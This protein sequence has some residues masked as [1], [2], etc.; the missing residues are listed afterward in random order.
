MER[1]TLGFSMDLFGITLF[2]IGK[3]EKERVVQRF[4]L[5]F[6]DSV[7]CRAATLEWITWILRGCRGDDTLVVRERKT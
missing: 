5:H 4:R 6:G 3:Y 2:D 7:N 1:L